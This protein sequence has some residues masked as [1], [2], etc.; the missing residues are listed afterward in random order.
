MLQS[1]FWVLFV[2]GVGFMAFFLIR[3]KRRQKSAQSALATR[4]QLSDKAFVDRYYADSPAMAE[5]A[6]RLREILAAHLEL[7]LGGLQPTDRLE[8]DFHAELEARPDLFIEIEE[9][10]DVSTTVFDD[11]PDHFPALKAMQTFDDLVS[12]VLDRP[13]GKHDLDEFR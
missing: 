7:D 4:P 2:I 12:Y 8:A 13:K 3:D 6:V 9:A 11:E 1:I 5:V 10:F